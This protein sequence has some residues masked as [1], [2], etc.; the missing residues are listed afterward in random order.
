M[1][2]YT[3]GMRSGLGTRV[4]SRS[5]EESGTIKWY[6]SKATQGKVGQG[7]ESSETCKS[8]KSVKKL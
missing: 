8:M 4:R 1:V 6:D 7:T 5:A 2:L 3:M